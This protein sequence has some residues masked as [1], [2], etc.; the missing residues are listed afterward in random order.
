MGQLNLNTILLYL[1]NDLYTFFPALGFPSVQCVVFY[2]FQ[3]GTLRSAHAPLVQTGHM[4]PI[5]MFGWTPIFIV[6]MIPCTACS[7]FAVV[8]EWDETWLVWLWTANSHAYILNYVDIY[9]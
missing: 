4:A 7:R 6:P 8:S 3:I 2:C 1:C 9:I 5:G